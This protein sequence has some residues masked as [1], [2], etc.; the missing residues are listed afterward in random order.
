MVKRAVQKLFRA[1]PAGLRLRLV[2][3]SQRKFTA[4]AAAV[5]V[6][7]AGEVLLLNHV[8]RPFSGWGLPGGF[9]DRGEQPESA[10]RRELMEEAGIELEELA[11]Y[12]VRTVN[13]HIEIIFTARTAGEAAVSSREI[14]DLGWFAADDLPE[15]MSEAQKRLIELVLAET[16]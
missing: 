10:I 12:R 11:M 9:I 15:K 16:D 13:A 7:D 4:S 1:I 3:M 14:M 8:L 5:V 2:R 6:N